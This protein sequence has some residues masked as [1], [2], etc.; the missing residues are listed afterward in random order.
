MEPARSAAVKPLPNLTS[1]VPLAQP[2]AASLEISC[3]RALP[4]S[5]SI[6]SGR[7]NRLPGKR[8]TRQIASRALNPE[9]N[10]G[11]IARRIHRCSRFH[12]DRPPQYFSVP[13]KAQNLRRRAVMRTDA[14][15]ALR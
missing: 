5:D 12:S 4:Q 15:L 11:L 6:P 10:F 13:L 8:L 1:K 9:R 2:L 14:R 3:R 7:S